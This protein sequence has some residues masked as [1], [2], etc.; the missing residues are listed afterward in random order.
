MDKVKIVITRLNFLI[1]VFEIWHLLPTK[2]KFYI[3][4]LDFSTKRLIITYRKLSNTYEYFILHIS[5]TINR[6]YLLTQTKKFN[7]SRHG[8]Y[9]KYD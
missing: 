6:R 4:D 1:F 7:F 8:A 9:H 5:I 3:I 2:I